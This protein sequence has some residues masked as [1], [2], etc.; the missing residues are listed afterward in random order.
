MSLYLQLPLRMGAGCVPVPSAPLLKV[1]APESCPWRISALGGWGVC[2]AFFE[3]G[4]PA[5]L[6][7]GHCFQHMMKINYDVVKRWIN[8][9]QE[10][11]SSDNI[12]VQVHTQ[13]RRGWKYMAYPAFELVWGSHNK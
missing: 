6:I 11:A 12:M 1:I 8:E 5:G 13:G 9:A 3:G 7:L 10:A 2:A 4:S